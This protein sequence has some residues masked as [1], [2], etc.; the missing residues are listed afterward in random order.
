M[1]ELATHSNDQSGATMKAAAILAT[2]FAFAFTANAQAV[3]AVWDGNIIILN[4]PAAACPLKK[5]QSHQA[6]FRPKIAGAN[7]DNTQMNI[8]F[9]RAA[10]HMMPTSPAN[11]QFHG[12]GNW[13]GL[14][15]KDNA[16]V[17]APSG[18]WNFTLSPT[19]IAAATLQIDMTS[20]TFTMPGSP[21]PSLQ[22]RGSFTKRP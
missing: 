13:S 14:F 9:G 2:I 7:V 12:S 18:A 19:V 11:S 1:I 4:V 10:L 15:L 17:V 16:L 21:C 8:Y 3:E 5:G 22:I 20:G 6:V